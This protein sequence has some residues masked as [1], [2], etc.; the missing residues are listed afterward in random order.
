[1]L[2]KSK[3]SETSINLSTR[4]LDEVSLN[5]KSLLTTF[6]FININW[7]HFDKLKQYVNEFGVDIIITKFVSPEW[8]QDFIRDITINKLGQTE[9]KLVVRDKDSVSKYLIQELNTIVP[10]SKFNFL[11]LS[12][13]TNEYNLNKGG[14]FITL[15]NTVSG[16]LPID[17]VENKEPLKRNKKIITLVPENIIND[18]FCR[19]THFLCLK[20]YLPNFNIH[21]DYVDDV[22]HNDEI[23]AVIPT[24]PNINDYNI[25]FYHPICLTDKSYNNQ[26]QDIFNYNHNILKRFFPE[27]RIIL[28]N[29]FFEAT[30]KITYPPIFNRILLR[31]GNNFRIIF[32]DQ[33]NIELKQQIINE[34]KRYP[35]IDYH[36]IDTSHLHKLNGNIHC[37]FKTIPN[38]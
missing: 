29:L 20:V 22:F 27:N 36:F 11:G 25:W 9:F 30:G 21:K 24:G 28:F 8:G 35:N 5:T 15:P 18:D 33:Q 38:I 23:L 2:K 14:N 1:M 13:N 7:Q 16:I 26:L 10:N 6:G 17:E 32:P 19:Y 4:Y 12:N 3:H 34:I 37:G 31:K